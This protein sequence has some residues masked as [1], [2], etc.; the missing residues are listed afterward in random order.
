MYLISAA[1]SGGTNRLVESCK[2]DFIGMTADK[3]KIHTSVLS[4]NYLVPM[5]VEEE[6]YVEAVNRISKQHGI[7]LFIPN[8]DSEVFTTTKYIEHIGVKTFLP[9]HE[10]VRATFDKWD[11]YLAAK[12]AGVEVA[13]TFHITSEKEIEKAFESLEQRPL[14]CRVKSGSGSRYTSKVLSVEDAKHYIRHQLLL[15]S[16]PDDEFLISEYLPGDD[17][18]VMTIWKDGHIKMCKMAK[19]TRYFKKAGESPP[20]VLES[21]FDPKIES[22][23]IESI[24]KLTSS[25]NGVLNVDIKCREDG[26][27]VVTEINAGRFYYN[28]QLFNSGNFHAF[29]IFLKLAEGEDLAY[30]TEDPEV[31]FIREQD[32]EPYIIPKH[33][34]K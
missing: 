2:S 16:L 4:T 5:A 17:I 7:E 29:E 34:L 8:S 24:Q 19:R 21:F 13:E 18:A 15:N 6:A 23:V 27:P 3:Y 31:I 11:F 28:M 26:T 12:K 25:A 10:L 32:N 9:D 20:S 22:F 33:L 30:C 14:W 1:G